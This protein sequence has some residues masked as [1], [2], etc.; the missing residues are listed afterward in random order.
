MISYIMLISSL[1][2]YF[3]YVAYH[4][5]IYLISSLE[6]YW[7]SNSLPSFQLK[8]LFSF[9]VLTFSYIMSFFFP[10]LF[11]SLLFIV[12]N[13]GGFLL[14]SYIGTHSLFFLPQLKSLLEPFFLR[15][16]IGIPT[17]VILELYS[18]KEL[19]WNSSFFY[20]VILE[21]F[22]TT[23]VILEL[24]SQVFSSFLPLVILELYSHNELYWNS[25]FFFRVILELLKRVY[26]E[27]LDLP[28]SFFLPRRF[29]F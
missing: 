20:R 1:H 5:E 9:N 28:H 16:Y 24:Y 29:F 13:Y 7:N 19:Y 15:K 18:H 8:S 3:F 17:R 12:K 23:R 14:E 10:P 22:S 21:L 27:T 26:F 6:L 4:Q 11:Q 25:S 2:L